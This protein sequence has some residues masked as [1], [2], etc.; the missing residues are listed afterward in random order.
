MQHAECHVA[1]YERP[2]D[3]SREAVKVSRFHDRPTQCPRAHGTPAPTVPTLLTTLVSWVP[4]IAVTACGGV[5]GCP[6]PSPYSADRRPF[7]LKPLS[8]VPASSPGLPAHLGP[9]SLYPRLPQA[10]PLIWGRLGPS[11]PGQAIWPRTLCPGEVVSGKNPQSSASVFKTTELKRL[12]QT[13]RRCVLSV[14]PVSS[15]C[16]ALQRAWLGVLWPSHCPL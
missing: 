6:R 16:S 11:C 9:R 10:S 15:P 3:S 5:P 14:G 12:P 8:P 2:S 4:A 1:S 13:H 7:H